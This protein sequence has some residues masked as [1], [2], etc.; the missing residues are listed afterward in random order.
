MI[1]YRFMIQERV[2]LA[3]AELSKFVRVKGVYVFGSQVEGTP[4]ELSDIDVAVFAEDIDDWDI[5]ERSEVIA[6]VQKEAGDD[7]EIHFF[8]AKALR[9]ADPA[10]FAAYILHHGIQVNLSQ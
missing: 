6:R 7:L 2:Q 9:H 10:S 5:W 4:H 3:A 1:H 8:P